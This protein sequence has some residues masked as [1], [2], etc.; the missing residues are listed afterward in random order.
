MPYWLTSD[1]FTYMNSNTGTVLGGDK[2]ARLGWIVALIMFS[3]AL[4][5][6]I[7]LMSVGN[8]S[9]SSVR[10]E[11]LD[12]CTAPGTRQDAECAAELNKLYSLLEEVQSERED[13]A[14][15]SAVEATPASV[16]VTPL[17]PAAT[18]TPV[19]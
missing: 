10:E 19:L 18:A 16:E 2:M 7:R 6:F 12:V 4:L 11:V 14:A 13:A 17:T 3:I 8:A 9:F 15:E 5:L 1:N